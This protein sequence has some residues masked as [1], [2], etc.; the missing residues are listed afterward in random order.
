MES[1]FM[2]SLLMKNCSMLTLAA[3]LL[4][5]TVAAAVYVKDVELGPRDVADDT[6]RVS[7][8]KVDKMLQLL[9]LLRLSMLRMLN[10]DSVYCC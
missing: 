4:H 2:S 1:L 9:L 3:I 6:Y 7:R 10:S 5:V 8:K